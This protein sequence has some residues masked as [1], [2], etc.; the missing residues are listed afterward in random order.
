MAIFHWKLQRISAILLIPIA[1][2]TTFYLFNIG[3]LSY[4]DVTN[5]ILSIPA[6]LLIVF[7]SVILFMHSSLGIETILEDYIHDMKTQSLLVNLSKFI[8]VILFL[9]TLVSLIVI[10][11]N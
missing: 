2:Y 10:K 11:G 9:L 8:H 3:S 1:I 4:A 7:M 6:I 5:D